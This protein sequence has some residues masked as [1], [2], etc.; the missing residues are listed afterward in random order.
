ME[1]S[2]I[3]QRLLFQIVKI[4]V[5]QM[6]LAVVFVGIA[7]ATPAKGQ[8]M[9]DSKVTLVLNNVSLESALSEI[10]KTAH[11]KF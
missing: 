8:E 2:F 9:L 3:H 1:K 6:I 11:V 7:M 5:F 4:S 10:E